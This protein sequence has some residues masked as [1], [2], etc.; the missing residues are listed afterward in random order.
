M[1]PEKK[2]LTF[3][4]ELAKQRNLIISSTPEG[5]LIFWQSVE[6]GS[7]VARLQQGNSPLMSVTPF[8]SPQE[9]YS[10]I[11]GIEPVIAGL[12]GSQFTVKNPRLQGVIR[13]VTFDAP[14]TLDADIKGAVEAKAGRMFGSMASYSARV[15][16][17]RDPQGDLWEPNTTVTLLAPDA[18]IYSE[19]EFVVRSIEFDREGAAQT[20]TLNLVIPG[21]FSGEIPEALPWDG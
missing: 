10:H 15:S 17:W 16:T 20:A 7:P 14:D 12:A 5:A 19:Y 11:T 8:F 18:M 1:E 4:T 21:S 2:V 9:Y 13:P 6:A 3:L